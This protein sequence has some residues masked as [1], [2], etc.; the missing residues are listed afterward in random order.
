MAPKVIISA[1]LQFMID[2][3]AD[4]RWKQSK[5]GVMDIPSDKNDH[6]MDAM[7]YI[8]TNDEDKAKMVKKMI[9]FHKEIRQ[10]T[11]M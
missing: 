10:W 11:P 3:I 7:K 5:D 6:A 1:D 9:E 4:Y 8:L 2:E